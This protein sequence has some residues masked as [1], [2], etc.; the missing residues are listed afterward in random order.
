MR[1]VSACL[2]MASTLVPVMTGPALA[3]EPG[4]EFNATAIVDT[5]QGSRRM[6]L[7]LVVSRFTPLEEAQGL[8]AVLA[9]GGQSALLGALRGRA[10]GRLRLGGMEQNLSLVVVEPEGDGLRYTVVTGRRIDVSERDLGR[11][12]LD[13]PFGVATFV[14]G[15]FGR[16]EGRIWPAAALRIDAEGQVEVE[17]YRVDPGRI[18]DVRKV[19]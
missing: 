12:S 7:T 3:G 14:V 16:G 9:E 19:R 10:D 5:P 1:T 2:I 13:Y 17:Q 8:R 6:P 15:D 11:E 18:V 4:R